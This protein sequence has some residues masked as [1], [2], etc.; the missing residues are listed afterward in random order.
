MPEP[1]RPPKRFTAPLVGRVPWIVALVGSTLG[2]IIIGLAGSD[3]NLAAGLVIFF[4]LVLLPLRA[5]FQT[6]L[7]I[8]ATGWIPFEDV[9]TS[10]L[11]RSLFEFAG[12]INV[13]GLR[14][15]GSVLGLSIGLF[16][17]RDRLRELVLPG[18]LRAAVA[19][20]V[21]AL[22]WATLT[23]LWAPDTLE[24]ARFVCKL[25]LPLLI[26]ATIVS[27]PLRLGAAGVARQMVLVLTIALLVSIPYGLLA[28]LVDD[29][30]YLSDTGDIAD[31]FRW[32]GASGYAFFLSIVAILVLSLTEHGFLR[33]RYYAIAGLALV[34]IP[35]TVKRLPVGAV[36]LAISAMVAAG[37]VRRALAPLGI[38]AAIL[39]VLFFPPLVDRNIYSESEGG[40]QLEDDA[41][42]RG[43]GVV[44]EAVTSPSDVNSVIRLEGRETLWGIAFDRL[45]G[46]EHIYGEGSNAFAYYARSE[47]RSFP[48]LHGEFVRLIYETGAV[49]LVLMLSSYAVMGI[50]FLISGIKSRKRTLRRGLAEAAIG[51][52]VFYVATWSTD[53]TLDY[54]LIGAYAWAVLGLAA[55]AHAESAEPVEEPKPLAEQPGP[56]EPVPGA[57]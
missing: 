14:L 9:F 25:L 30:L 36:G 37:G 32:A 38:L 56:A 39:L 17:L 44:S 4:I 22:A 8:L 43:V 33:R 48:Q 18:W 53:N 55:L 11:D 45:K 20:Y 24:G 16:S 3:A 12:G 27:D 7:L 2:S 51:V 42:S 50:G 29:L 54:Y 5:P 47:F 31:W 28:Y 49:G 26:G 41:V 40:P 10:G 34:Q 15:V 13:S 52:I 35:L 57:A 19:L 23:I 6:A 1:E 46:L 21:I